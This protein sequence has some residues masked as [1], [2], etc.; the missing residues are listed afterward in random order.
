MNWGNKILLVIIVFI[1]GML[2]LVYRTTQTNFELV[3]QDYYKQELRYQDIIDGAKSAN[4]LGSSIELKQTDAG[5]VLALPA[6][7]KNRIVTGT[8]WFYCAYNSAKDKKFTLKPTVEGLQI[9]SR[10]EIE[11]GTYTVRTNWKESGTNYYI[12]KKLTVL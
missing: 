11:P 4:A 6:E 10:Q 7:M 3:E 1:S 2:Y 9:F 5:I 8:V 12:E